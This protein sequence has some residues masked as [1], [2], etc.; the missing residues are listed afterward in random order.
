M[1]GGSG[2]S[3]S[4]AADNNSSV[5]SIDPDQSLDADADKK[6]QEK[7]WVWNYFVKENR[8]DGGIY[9]SCQVVVSAEDAEG[10]EDTGPAVTAAVG[11]AGPGRRLCQTQYKCNQG[12]KNMIRHLINGH[13]IFKTT[14][15][16]GD[17]GANTRKIRSETGAGKNNRHWA[18]DE[19]LGLLKAYQEVKNARG[20]DGDKFDEL[21]EEIFTVFHRLIPAATRSPKALY[22]K[23]G[24]LVA[25]YR[26]ISE[27]ATHAHSRGTSSWWDLEEQDQR[28]MLGKNRMPISKAVYSTIGLVLPRSLLK[29]TTFDDLPSADGQSVSPAPQP[30]PQPA[31]LPAPAPATRAPRTATP[32]QASTAPPPPAPA[33]QARAGRGPVAD[34]N[35][36]QW[37][38]N[39]PNV[40][41][42]AAPFPVG[43]R[44]A[45]D[46]ESSSASSSD[47]SDDAD[48]APA[49]RGSVGFGLD[50]PRK[51]ARTAAAPA[52]VPPPAAAAPAAF[53]PTN[54]PP[55]AVPGAGSKINTDDMQQL[56][57]N[58]LVQGEQNR[59][60]M[61]Q[62]QEQL[63][64]TLRK[65][66][67][68]EEKVSRVM[69][70]VRR[71][72]EDVRR[73]VG[74]E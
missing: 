55:A 32:T 25:T 71:V 9:A 57:L 13:H 70:D 23:F 11:T 46:G 24:S 37:F 44:G 61:M 40:P 20:V 8:S 74:R 16:P 45:D 51:R 63:V 27:H 54:V 26:Y 1:A 39:L 7:S 34:P 47:D 5:S 73:S 22:E 29:L 28:R 42:P 56:L 58:V 43:K 6:K 50:L 68:R 18:E 53:T 3:G 10:P 67:K 31:L 60:M 52:A 2:S 36:P 72:M 66:A 62:Q 38:Y 14:T 49:F 4:S 19:L 17:T 33:S 21:I 35:Q 48:D 12:T 64:G 41:L 69:E 30:A 65:L 15:I 59:R